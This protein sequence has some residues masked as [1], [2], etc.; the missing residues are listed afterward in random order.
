MWA[1]SDPV[2]Q[3][4]DR[5]YEALAQG[6]PTKAVSALS[7]ALGT[8]TDDDDRQAVQC[9]LGRAHLAAG[10]AAEAEQGLAEV[11]ADHACGAKAAYLRAEALQAL[12][13]VDEAVEIYATVGG[14]RLG[15]GSR[16][17]ERRGDC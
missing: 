7:G 8:V 5:A 11:A 3:A 16:C 12:G 2:Q 4:T 9:L 1:T 14:A 10:Q 15:P 13:R 6:N 17:D